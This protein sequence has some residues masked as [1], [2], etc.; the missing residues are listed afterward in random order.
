MK[1]GTTMRLKTK[2]AVLFAVIILGVSL[3]QAGCFKTGN[4]LSAKTSTSMEAV[5]KDYQQALVQIDATGASLEN[6]I[7]PGQPDVKKAFKEYS[8]NVDKMENLGKLLLEHSDKMSAQGKDYFA[9]WEKQGN[10]YANPEI[11]AQSEQ[12][13]ADLSVYFVKISEASVGVKGGSK[14]YLSDIREIRTYLSNDLTPKGVEAI[15]PVAHKAVDDGNSLKGAIEP[16]LSAIGGVRAE[17]APG[18]TK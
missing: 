1:R 13:R 14:A 7:K 15:T 17:L 10:T 16:V 9:E 5:E 4:Q 12:R 8:A 3:S 18:G 6:L 2:T 11:Q